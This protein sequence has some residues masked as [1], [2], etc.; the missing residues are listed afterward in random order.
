MSNGIVDQYGC[1]VCYRLINVEYGNLSRQN[2]NIMVYGE[3]FRNYL[4]KDVE[5]NHIYLN[6]EKEGWFLAVS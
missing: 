2:S 6:N 1:T 3:P 4:T 5:L